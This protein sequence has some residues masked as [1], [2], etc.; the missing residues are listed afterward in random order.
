MKKTSFPRL[1]IGLGL[2]IIFALVSS[3]NRMVK[4]ITRRDQEINEFLDIGDWVERFSAV[5]P[6]VQGAYSVSFIST[7]F[8]SGDWRT[9]RHR[10]TLMQVVQLCI[11]PALFEVKNG[12]PGTSGPLYI[13]DHPGHESLPAKMLRKYQVVSYYGKGLWL[14]QKTGGES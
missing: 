3:T 14:L 8:D 7:R 6:D 13:F 11:A 5:R 1:R 9:R 12:K 4:A 2:L 10:T